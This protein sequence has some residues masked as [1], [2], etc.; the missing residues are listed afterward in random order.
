MSEVRFQLLSRTNCHLCTEMESLLEEILPVFGESY[1]VENVDSRRE[2]Q[3]QYGEVV[4]VL[5]RDGRAVAKIRVDRGQLER[6]VRKNRA[7]WRE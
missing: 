5:L 2:W 6:I 3:E 4:P 1:S 7:G